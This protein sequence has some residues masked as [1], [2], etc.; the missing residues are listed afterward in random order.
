MQIFSQF[1]KEWIE[2]YYKTAQIGKDG[3]FYTSVSAS[4]FFG[5]AI[6]NYILQNLENRILKLPLNIIDLGANNLYLLNDIYDFLDALS[7]NVI[8]NCNFIA[9]ESNFNLEFHDFK[10]RNIIIYKNLKDLNPLLNNSFFI[11]NEFF[12]ALPC[13]LYDGVLYNNPKF[14]FVNNNKIEFLPLDLNLGQILEIFKNQNVTR[15]EIPLSYFDF[16]K[17]FLE[18]NPQNKKWIFLIFDYGDKIH[19]NNFNIRIFSKHK[20]F[21]LFQNA[22]NLQ[23]DL[24][25]QNL[26]SFFKTS[27]LTYNVPFSILNLAFQQIG[28]KEILFKKQRIALIDDF[29]ILD[30]LQKFYNNKK[31][32]NISYLRESNKIKTLLNLLNDNFK[33]SIYI[34]FK[35]N[36]I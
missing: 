1:F 35:P 2:D 18:I 24:E 19:S 9:V 17:T 16:C 26:E 14:A 25:T 22:N 32:S 21:M 23:N 13:E 7:V 20:T 30:L 29:K 28:A 36:T 12:D 5:G 33:T 34:N 6:A 8:E 27:D 11:A 31:S 4:K 15:S 3:D 10:K